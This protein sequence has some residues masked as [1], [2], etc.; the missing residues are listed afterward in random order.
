MERP[1]NAPLAMDKPLFFVSFA[2]SKLQEAQKDHC[3]LDWIKHD[4]PALS[5]PII[6]V[7]AKKKL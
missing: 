4:T 1:L 2:S 6:Y 7:G 5:F 3:V